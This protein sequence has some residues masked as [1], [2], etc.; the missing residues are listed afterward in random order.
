MAFLGPSLRR[1]KV[2][3][4]PVWRF[5]AAAWISLAVHAGI[6]LAL[7]LAGVLATMVPK[8]L[9][10]EK[11]ELAQVSEKD[12]EQNRTIRSAPVPDV[13]PGP[14]AR[15]PRAEPP[16][17][18]PPQREERKKQVVDVAPSK[19]ERPPDDPRFL[20]ERNSRVEKETRSRL[21]GTGK[22]R[23]R[24]AAPTPG[25]DRKTDG[26]GGE[27]TKQARRGQAG[28]DEEG[29]KKRVPEDRPA[30]DGDRLARLDRP[31][32]PRTRPDGPGGRDEDG[33]GIPGLPG[34]PG[35]GKQPLGDPRLL[36]S[37]E[38]MSRIAAGP[39]NDALP[40]DIEEGEVTALNTKAYRFATFWNRFKQDV[41]DHW[42]PG[43]RYEIGARDPD[44][45]TFG[46]SDRVTGL[47]IVLDGSGA[48]KSIE[49]VSPSGLDFLDRV[50]VKS[51]KDASPFYNV[52]KGLLDA[53]GE[54]SF[55]FGFLVGGNRGIPVRPRWQP[56]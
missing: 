44:G 4:R 49:V 25:E 8:L 17:P 31:A 56:Q 12:W 20:S 16:P 3:D 38:D 48:V 21:Q 22:W 10:S 2:I 43:V 19:D 45:A 11:V 9:R 46:R 50:A 52:P 23:N 28:T 14:V 55:E 51:V 5:L 27:G 13:P 18:P 24:A 7:L 6:L 29:G 15:L 30:P 47:H 35:E 32:L 33:S 42:F 37:L 39:S 1:K 40:A 41:A 53:K 54:L 36:P 34:E 26:A